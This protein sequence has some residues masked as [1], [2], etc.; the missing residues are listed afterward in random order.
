MVLPEGIGEIKIEANNTEQATKKSFALHL[1]LTSKLCRCLKPIIFH[2]CDAYDASERLSEYQATRDISST[3]YETSQPETCTHKANL[4]HKR[5]KL[6]L[7]VV[8]NISVRP[9]PYVISDK[10]LVHMAGRE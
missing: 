9:G 4:M 6:S 3:E 7:L 8:E 5:R 2:S 1:S 10:L